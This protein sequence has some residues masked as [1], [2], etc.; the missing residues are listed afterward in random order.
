MSPRAREPDASRA[1]LSAFAFALLLVPARTATA[2]PP[3]PVLVDDRADAHSLFDRMSVVRDSRGTLTVEQVVDREADD[4]HDVEPGPGGAVWV[5]VALRAESRPREPWFLSIAPP[6]DPGT[7]HVQTEQRWTIAPFAPGWAPALVPIPIEPGTRH[8][9]VRLPRLGAPPPVFALVTRSGHDR[10]HARLLVTQA[11]YL[12]FLLAIAFLNLA[13][14]AWVRERAQLWYVAFV[15]ATAGYFAM[16]TGMLSRFV[17]PSATAGDLVRPEMALLAVTA[18]TGAQFSRHF[19]DTRRKTPRAD[20]LLQAYTLFAGVVLMV[21]WLAPGAVPATKAIGILLPFVAITAGVAAWRAGSSWARFYLA[22]WVSLTFGVFAY[23]AIGMPIGLDSAAF[24]AGSA[25]EAAFLALALVDRFRAQRN[26]LE[27]TRSDLARADRLTTLGQLVAG[28]AHEVNNP[29]NVIT[30]NLPILR[31]YVAAMRPHVEASAT[32]DTKLCGLSVEALFADLQSLIANM[33]HGSARI[34]AIVSELKGYARPDEAWED[35]DVNP[36]VERAVR[37]VGTRLEKA[38]DRFEV[39]LGS[40]LP[41]VHMSPGRIEQVVVNLLVNAGQASAGKAGSFVVVSTE[42]ESDGALVIVEDSGPGV[43]ASIRDR[44][45]EPF[46]TTKSGESG[47][48]LGL[49]ISRR[50]VVDH[51]GTLELRSEEGAPTRFV[52]R[53]PG[54]GA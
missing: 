19:L 20:L 52:V 29:N 53:L 11:L 1:T 3:P 17:A 49:A 13:M 18:I 21:I 24:Q 12:G 30:F 15:A 26:E 6:F 28:V 40:G 9:L 46:F 2:A 50:I 22:G 23:A 42:R 8:L 38:V 32:P 48:G 47:T 43:P 10:L 5:R 25:L 41:R 34:T 16:H 37:L 27:R 35:A 7:V 31:E 39:R 54:L 44:I 14:F 45:F 4:L 36:V 33:E 51:G